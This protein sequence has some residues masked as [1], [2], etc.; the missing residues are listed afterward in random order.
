MELLLPAGL[1]IILG[2]LSPVITGLFTKISMSRKTK[3]T[4]AIIVSAV[5][6]G[7]WLLA[8]G[9]AV[10][11]TGAGVLALIQS[12]ALAIGAV[13]GLSQVVYQYLFKGTDLADAVAEKGITDGES[14]ANGD[15]FL[16]EEY[17]E[18]VEEELGA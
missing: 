2:A 16:A 17:P 9:G 7:V 5:L 6:A 4:V 14:D 11:V 8:S 18:D 10:I 3:T 13:Y 12:V 15:G 1:L